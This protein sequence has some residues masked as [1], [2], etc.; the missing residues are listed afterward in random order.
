MKISATIG[1]SIQL[2]RVSDTQVA[3]TASVAAASLTAFSARGQR[4]EAP[5]PSDNNVIM[6]NSSVMFANDTAL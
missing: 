4:V 2:L 5:Q 6:P 1:S 3:Y